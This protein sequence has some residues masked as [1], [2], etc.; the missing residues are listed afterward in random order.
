VVAGADLDG[1]IAAGGADEFLDGP[2]GAVL[3]EPGDGEGG[4]DDR[5]VGLDRVPLAVVDRPGPQVVLSY[6]E[7]FFDVP[8]PVIAPDDEVRCD[9]RAVGT[10]GQVGDVALQPGQ[11][12]G[13]SLQLAVDAF[14][15]PSSWMNGFRLT[16]ARP[17]TAFAALAT[18]S[19]V[20]RSVRRAR[21]ALNW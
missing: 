12:P 17:A 6:P 18:C 2:A 15:A 19:P 21:S 8:E 11:V 14:V 4:E 10:G 13:P 20:P 1:A 3:Y 5:E 7:A 16:G 9:R